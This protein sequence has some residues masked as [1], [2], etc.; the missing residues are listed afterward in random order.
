MNNFKEDN[1]YKLLEEIIKYYKY[2]NYNIIKNSSYKELI[3][4]AIK[5]N[6][7]ALN[8][9]SNNLQNNKEFILSCIQQNGYALKNLY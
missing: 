1:Y 3:L 2:E 8:Y 7:D 5:Y 6:I 4:L 9:A